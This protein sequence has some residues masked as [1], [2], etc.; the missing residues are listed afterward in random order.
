MSTDA[1]FVIGAMSRPPESLAP[2]E[3]VRLLRL[4]RALGDVKDVYEEVLTVKL[5]LGY[6]V[7]GA[8]LKPGRRWRAWNDATQAATVLYQNF[9]V[10]AVKPVSPAAAEKLGLA[11]KQYAA[12]GAHTPEAELK[13]HY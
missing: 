1:G 4:I 13:A 11:G 8:S 2:N 7:D 12:I 6:P 5:K 10:K 3:L 9:G